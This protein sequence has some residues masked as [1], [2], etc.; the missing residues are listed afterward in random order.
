MTWILGLGFS[1]IAGHF[2]VEFF[3]SQ[4]RKY[5]GLGDKPPL[6]QSY[7]G[8][9]PWL[10]GGLERVFFTFLVAFEVTGTP[11]AM[12]GWLALKLATNWNHPD[13]KDNRSEERAV[14]FSA[15]VAGLVS[16]LF[17]LLGGQICAQ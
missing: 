7:R 6:T 17:A 13:Y 9:P 11:A 3:L 5:M 16:M 2:A 10:T 1:L 15:L 4:L 14:A 8:V 12:I